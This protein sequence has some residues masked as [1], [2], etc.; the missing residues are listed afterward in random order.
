MKAHAIVSEVQYSNC[1][2]RYLILWRHL[3]GINFQALFSSHFILSTSWNI[4]VLHI[5][6]LEIMR[7]LFVLF[8][9]I[10]VL[11]YFA[12]NLFCNCLDHIIFLFLLIFFH[13][14]LN[15]CTQLYGTV[16]YVLSTI[17]V[18]QHYGG[19]ASNNFLARSLRS[20]VLQQ[21]SFF[22]S[23]YPNRSN[24]FIRTQGATEGERLFEKQALLKKGNCYN[25]NNN[26]DNNYCKHFLSQQY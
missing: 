10:C 26:N 17:V 13:F 5:P 7:F 19:L 18:K 6:L 23:F 14:F 4:S 8:F 1:Q 11:S 16:K 2:F 24:K 22:L 15:Y 20:S 21:R 9:C 12:S 3:S 25:N